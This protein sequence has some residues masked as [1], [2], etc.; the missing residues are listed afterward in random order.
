MLDLAGDASEVRLEAE[1]QLLHLREDGIA[2]LQA[3]VEVLDAFSLCHVGLHGLALGGVQLLLHA[4]AVLPEVNAFQ[5]RLSHERILLKL[6]QIL[7]DSAEVRRR[8][9]LLAEAQRVQLIC[10]SLR[11]LLGVHDLQ[12][13]HLGAVLSTSAPPLSRILE[14]LSHS[15]DS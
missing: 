11:G 12:R 15:Y 10:E 4:L 7:Y 6:L 2:A 1:K 9:G 3:A 13:G 5:E 14:I 8:H